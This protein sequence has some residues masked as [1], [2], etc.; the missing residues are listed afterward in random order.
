MSDTAIINLDDLK[1]KQECVHSTQVPQ[2]HYQFLCSVDREIISPFFQHN[3]SKQKI[4][5]NVNIL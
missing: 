3:F 4:K 5:H 2:S 1:I